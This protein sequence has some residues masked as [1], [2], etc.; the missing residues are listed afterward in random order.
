MRITRIPRVTRINGRRRNFKIDKT[1]IAKIKQL[2]GTI[3]SNNCLKHWWHVIITHKILIEYITNDSH[4]TL[5]VGLFPFII[6]NSFP[7]FLFLFYDTISTFRKRIRNFRT[8]SIWCSF[9]IFQL[10]IFPST[11]KSIA[12]AVCNLKYIDANWNARVCIPIRQRITREDEEQSA[13]R[14][15]LRFQ[16]YLLK[17]PS[18]GLASVMVRLTGEPPISR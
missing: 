6:S 14:P 11:F 7:L 3:E 2:I 17:L 10:P 18:S 4:N 1:K 16:L 8:L 5:C 12:W 13:F 9:T 15:V